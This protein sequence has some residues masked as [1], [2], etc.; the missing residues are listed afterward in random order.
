VIVTTPRHDRVS[1]IFLEACEVSGEERESYLNEACAG[2]VELRREVESLLRHDGQAPIETGAGVAHAASALGHGVSEVARGGEGTTA[3]VASEGTISIPGYTILRLLGEGGMGR[4]YLAE[5]ETLGRRV[6]IK[7]VSERFSANSS[8]VQRFVREARAMATVEH[9]HIVRVYTFGEIAGRQ[10]LIMEYVEGESLAALIKRT[11]KLDVTVSLRILSETVD[12]L[13]AAWRQGIVHR[14]VK[15]ANILLDE[16]QRVRV[17]DFGLAKGAE[18]E[19]DPRI[20][21]VGEVLGTPHYVS[22]EQARGEG[23]SDFRTDVYS[24]GI[25]LYEMLTGAPP[26]QGATPHSIVDQHLHTPLPSLQRDRPDVRGE[27]EQLC[28]WM[29]RKSPQDRPESYELLRQTV[30]ALLGKEPQT[31]GPAPPLPS[32]LIPAPEEEIPLFVGREQ[33]L[34]RLT[35][36]LEAALAGKGQVALVTGEAGSGKTALINEF[37]RRAQEDHADLIVAAGNCD[38]Q[39]GVGDPYL[40]FREV[41]SLL[42]ADLEFRLG[43]REI[44]RGQARRLWSLLPLAVEAVVDG[45]P[46]LLETFISGEALVSRATAFTPSPARWRVRLEELVRRNASTP[47]DAALQQSYL[48]EQYARTLHALAQ[49]HPLLLQLED[50]QWADG[51]SC[52]LLFHLVRRIANERILIVGTYRPAEIELE[53]DEKRH[54]MGPVLGELQRQFGQLRIQVGEEETREFIDQLLDSEPNEFCDEFRDRLFRQTRGHPLF[55]VELLSSMREQEMLIQ[56]ESDRWIEGPALDWEILPA[57]VEGAIGERVARLPEKQSS[58]LTLASVQGEEFVAEVLAQVEGRSTREIVALLSGELDKRHRLVA[59]Q[60]IRRMDGQRISTYRFRHN[61]FQKYL[62]GQMDEMERAYAHEDV[63]NALE[64]LYAENADEVA[65]QLAHHFQAAGVVPKTV[66]YLRRAGER[67]SRLSANEEAIGHLRRALNIVDSQPDSPERAR[68]ELALQLDLGPPLLGTAGPGSEELSRAYLRARELCD[69]VGAAPQLFQTLFLLVHHHANQGRASIALELSEQL[70][71]VVE[72]AEEPL[73]EVFAYWARGFALLC[74]GRYTESLRDYEHVISIYDHEQ[75]SA[76]TYVFGMDPAAG[77]LSMSGAESWILGYPDQ[78]REYCRRAVARAREVNH[79]SSLAQ[80]LLQ[81]IGVGVNLRDYES[82]SEQV[83]EL[84]RLST[85]HG[86]ALFRAWGILYGGVLLSVRGEH[87]EAIARMHQGI[88]DARATGSNLGL[89]AALAHLAA[90]YQRAGRFEEAMAPVEEG[91]AIVD[92]IDGGLE[93][94]L[95]RLQGELLIAG[96]P[97]LAREAEA[98]FRQAIEMARSQQ[99]RSWEL[100]ATMSVGRLLRDLGRQDEARGALAE[101]YGWFGEGLD[102]PDLQD[103]AALLG[104]LS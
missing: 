22:P 51:G 36:S 80:A 104:E 90:A 17:A 92:S 87:R 93:P 6:A 35:R 48:F 78:A 71:E 27:V 69:Q 47:R 102:T 97:N 72:S 64:S 18:A 45:G 101:K 53:R 84:V 7:I 9:A 21:R 73:P 96:D 70:L 43:S 66:D 57:R 67:A 5:D 41:L 55:A 10:Y 1:K 61:L 13:A 68:Q 88:A 3:T 30:D 39:T 58:L 52:G 29:A 95:H 38:A 99:A 59:P 85:E 54:P 12:A 15:P 19:D 8:A 24:L 89:P 25:V 26:F 103:A 11:G 86:V 91:L 62:Y 2:D 31:V 34:E 60:G 37:A 81:N 82:L 28:E 83:D 40:P 49:K 77:S 32:F 76:L 79:P 50:L 46:D 98:C 4:V 42:T 23:E 75:H 94:E 33:E 16:E 20:T 44:H 100:R 14:D 74:L 65:H 63:G 56:N